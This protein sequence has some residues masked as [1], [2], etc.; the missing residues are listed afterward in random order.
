[1]PE[2]V[3]LNEV[4]IDALQK[5]E[6]IEWLTVLELD[7]SGTP[8]KMKAKLKAFRAGGYEGVDALEGGQVKETK[9][10]VERQVQKAAPKPKKEELA[11]PDPEQSVL[12]KMER[13]NPLFVIIGKTFTREH[14]F[15]LMSPGEAQH[16]FDHTEG[17]RPATPKELAE[18]YN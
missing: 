3:D 18:F 11:P 13:E 14:P 16:I 7:S 1:M 2:T 10:K 8:A 5:D 4:N 12:V 9:T 15:V 6:L 17:F